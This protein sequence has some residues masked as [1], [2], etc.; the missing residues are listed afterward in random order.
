MSNIKISKKE[1]IILESEALK[2]FFKWETINKVK[3]EK[4]CFNTIRSCRVGVF[5]EYAVQK[6]LMNTFEN[7]IINLKNYGRE[8]RIRSKSFRGK[9][10]IEIETINENIFNDLDIEKQTQKEKKTT[11]IINPVF[12][13]KIEVK[14]ITEGQPKGQIL[15]YHCDKY[16]NNN[17]THVAFCELFLNEKNKTAEIDIYLID[18]IKNIVKYDIAKNKFGKDCY[19]NPKYLHIV[20]SHK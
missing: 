8:E 15:Q 4:Q 20:K 19:T 17:F 7:E 13:K 18:R 16:L 1:Y 9:P 2:D 10:D 3:K 6:H 5:C 14:G 12:T 11:K